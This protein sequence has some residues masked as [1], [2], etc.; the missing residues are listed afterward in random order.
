[1]FMD[2]FFS[3]DQYSAKDHPDSPSTVFGHT[4]LCENDPSLGML[5]DLFYQCQNGSQTAP[6]P[7]IQHPQQ[8][9]Q[10][11]Q[12]PFTCGQDTEWTLGSSGDSLDIFQAQHCTE[13]SNESFFLEGEEVMIPP[14]VGDGEA[15]DT[16]AMV[17]KMCREAESNS[18]FMQADARNGHSEASVE[19]FREEHAR[20]R[21][22]IDGSL[23]F[24][25][26]QYRPQYAPAAAHVKSHLPDMPATLPIVPS[27]LETSSSSSSLARIFI[28]KT[29]AAGTKNPSLVNEL[30]EYQPLDNMDMYQSTPYK[31]ILGILWL[32]GGPSHRA[33]HNSSTTNAKRKSARTGTDVGEYVMFL[34][35]SRTGEVVCDGIKV[36]KLVNTSKGKEM[37]R[38][39]Q[40]SSFVEIQVQF[41]AQSYAHDGEKFALVVE[42]QG[43]RLFCSSPFS[44]NARRSSGSSRKRSRQTP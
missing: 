36:D 6:E 28:K 43:R 39:F 4:F 30:D 10:D 37:R 41:I 42:H 40:N 3:S 31:Y 8:L 29:R 33:R 21:P 7:S 26:G 15:I 25:R 2:I 38:R 20:K 17:A 32:K 22:R 16:A 34:L 24:A 23:D 5:D 19:K 11:L 1:M 9:Q 35:K 12:L 44:L 13:D 18:Q 27:S 14:G